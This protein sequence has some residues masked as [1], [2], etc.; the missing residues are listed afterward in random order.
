M[1]SVGINTIIVMHNKVERSNVSAYLHHVGLNWYGYDG[2]VNDDDIIDD[3]HEFNDTYA[4][5]I[6]SY[7][8]DYVAVTYYSDDNLY[9]FIKENFNDFDVYEYEE[10]IDKFDVVCLVESLKM[11]LL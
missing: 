2:S 4:Y 8:D 11:G 9:E 10:F 3:D 1:S 7:R 5:F 6:E